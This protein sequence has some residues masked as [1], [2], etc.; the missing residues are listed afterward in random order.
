MAGAWQILIPVYN[1][2]DVL[3]LL[4]AAIRRENTD[5]ILGQIRFTIVDDASAMEMPKDFNAHGFSLEVVRLNSNQ[6]HQRAIA[7]GISHCSTQS[8]ISGVIVMDSDGEDV[9]GDIAALLKKAEDV[10]DT[11]VFARRTRRHEGFLFVGFYRVYRVVFR[12]LTGQS[13]SFGNFSLIPQTLLKR[14]ANTSYLWGHYSGGIV[15]ARLPLCTVPLERG[16]RLCGTSKMNFVSLVLHGLSAISVAADIMAVRMLV[17]S[18]SLISAAGTGIVVVTILRLFT[19]M[20]IPG[21]AS[22]MVIG[23]S[24]LIMQTFLVSLFLVF[25]VLN[26]RMQPVA[27][28]AAVYNDFIES[29]RNHS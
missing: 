28:P 26:N 17:L 15:R 18:L 1:D 3:D 8:D 16:R 2:W 24:L 4:L 10:P 22:S 6:G 27:P 21:W 25:S 7:C 9:P 14:V 5:E 29:I 12:L 19:E 13:I 23:L 11:I 20:A